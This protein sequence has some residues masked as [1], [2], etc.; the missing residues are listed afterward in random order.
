MFGIMDCGGAETRT[1]E[2]YR[3]IDRSRLQ[4]DFLTMSQGPG[5]YDAEIESLG[6]VV[7]P[8]GSPSKVGV[9][10]HILQVIKVLKEKG[11]F[12]A[13]HAH[14][15][16]HAGIISLAA[17]LAGVKI[18]VVHSRSAGDPK[19]TGLGRKLYFSLMRALIALFATDLV[20]CGEDAG[21][22]LYGDR[23]IKMGKV[24][25]IKN[26]IDENRFRDLPHRNLELRKELG[27]GESTTVIGHV[28]SFSA[29]KNHEFLLSIASNLKKKKV[30]FEM[31]LVGDGQLRFSIEKRIEEA[32]LHDVITLL[33]IR[34]DVPQL[35]S[36]FDILLL[37]S[38][39]EGV[40]GVVVEAQA[41]GTPCVVSKSVT[42]EVDI[43]L[44]LLEF[45]SIDCEKDWC[46]AILKKG[47]KYAVDQRVVTDKLQLNGFT[48]DSS[49]EALYAIYSV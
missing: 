39:Y 16:Y 23:Q 8:I 5:Y 25:I 1:M 26:A 24:T 20:A 28:G 2:I 4:F 36:M 30:D 35:M 22:F 47:S 13:V 42:K 10:K 29:V 37:P 45:L 12:H 49:I 19:S 43:G 27:I 48:V 11:P 44:G 17:F 33:G 38:F 9:V 31:V 41:A 32:G 14:T 21:R 15:A 7:Y 3:R 18:R 34:S 6:G 46:D 40:P